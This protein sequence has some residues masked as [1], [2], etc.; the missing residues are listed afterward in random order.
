MIL[1]L[2]LSDP[3]FSGAFVLAG[4]GETLLL[5]RRDDAHACRLRRHVSPFPAKGAG[6]DE[7]V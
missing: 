4:K 3:A 6:K 7:I 2:T 5:K 1:L